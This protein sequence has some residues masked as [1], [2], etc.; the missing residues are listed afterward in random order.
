MIS[1][2]FHSFFQKRYNP[3]TACQASH[4]VLGVHERRKPTKVFALVEFSIYVP[5]E[6]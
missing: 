3:L 1:L 6:F 5:W 4:W 2:F